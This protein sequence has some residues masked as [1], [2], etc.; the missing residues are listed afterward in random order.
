M[1]QSTDAPIEA[2]TD[3]NFFERLKGI[4]CFLTK[5]KDEIIG[6]F[7][8]FVRLKK[9]SSSSVGCLL[10]VKPCITGVW[11]PMSSWNSSVPVRVH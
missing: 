1:N 2:Q 6:S 3:Q 10:V 11:S 4:T 7:L 8:S 9:L 5:M